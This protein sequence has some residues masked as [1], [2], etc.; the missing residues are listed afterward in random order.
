MVEKAIK[1]PTD[2]SKLLGKI[3]KIHN[4]ILDLENKGVSNLLS[5]AIKFAKPNTVIYMRIYVSHST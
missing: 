4:R 5:N 3:V 1:E 2:V